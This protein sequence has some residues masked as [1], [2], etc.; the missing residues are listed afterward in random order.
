MIPRKISDQKFP[1]GKGEFLIA[2]KIW[3]PWR[4][5]I[6]PDV[7]HSGHWKGHNAFCKT[8]INYNLVTRAAKNCDSANW[9]QILECMAEFHFRN[10]AIL[11]PV[12]LALWLAN[13]PHQ[14]TLN[15]WIF[16]LL[17][18]WIRKNCSLIQRLSRRWWIENL[19]HHRM[20]DRPAVWIADL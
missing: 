6:L 18:P 7:S 4:Q 13:E 16:W 9:L 3:R 2:G 14:E 8:N 1:E 15:S 10:G 5:Q 11:N 12:G 19:L 20:C 17:N